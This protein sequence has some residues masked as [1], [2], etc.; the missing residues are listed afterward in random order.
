M[1]VFMGHREKL[2]EWY[3]TDDGKLFLEKQS[4]RLKKY[5]SPKARDDAR[6]KRRKDLRKV[7]LDE[8]IRYK[9]VGCKQR[10]K[11]D[12][13]PFD[14][15]SEYLKSIYVT[16]CPYLD[17]ELSLTASSGNSMDGLSLDKIDPRK[18][19]T[20]GNVQ[21]ISYKANVMKQDVDIQTL[22]HFAK[23]V[24]EIHGDK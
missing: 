5:D 23:R 21:F 12:G 19:Y 17:I 20:K 14:L 7:D 6:N 11:R 1:G 4:A 24:L 18:G 8:N 2:S 3:K 13:I 15:D 10:A 9:L 22:I 16:R